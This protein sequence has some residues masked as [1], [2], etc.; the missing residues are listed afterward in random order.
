MLYYVTTR[1]RASHGATRTNLNS[2][3]LTGIIYSTGF[4]L[5]AV[6]L[7]LTN[8]YHGWC[9][10]YTELEML[11]YVILCVTINSLTLSVYTSCMTGVCFGFEAH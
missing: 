11:C 4:T 8:Q 2:E 6:Y 5:P 9:L 10:L 1:H 3:N 7:L